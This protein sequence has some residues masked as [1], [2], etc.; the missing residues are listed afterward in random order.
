MRS[1]AT[2]KPYILDRYCPTSLNRLLNRLVVEAQ[3]DVI[4]LA[5]HYL[6][7]S[8]PQHFRVPVVVD[9]HDITHVMYERYAH[10][11]GLY[12]KKWHGRTQYRRM[13]EF[14]S[15]IP[16][17][18]SMCTTVSDEDAEALAR[19]SDAS[20][21]QVVPNGVDIA[22]FSPQSVMPTPAHQFD[23]VFV[24]SFDYAPNIQGAQLLCEKVMPLVWAV[25]PEASVGL[26]GRNPAPSVR[27]LSR[28][29]RIRITGGVS[30]VRTYL[31][32]AKIVV[33]PLQLGGGTKLKILEAMAMAK[34]VVSTRIGKEGIRATDGSDILIGDTPQNMASA[35]V[36]LLRDKEQRVK[37]GQ[38]GR[39]LVELAYDWEIIGQQL[40]DV[41]QSASRTEKVC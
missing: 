8:A 27:R 21:I 5:A 10:N 15:S 16:K 24:G 25:M 29:Q 3:S 30:D 22:F 37:L 11:Q 23:I 20:N 32:S 31:A 2:G 12:I 34:P 7:D 6:T 17:R 39:R 1:L 33:I 40:D 35:I 9:F 4:F 36:T 28:D 13:R 26:V 38:A 18:V 41:L 19:V 14:E